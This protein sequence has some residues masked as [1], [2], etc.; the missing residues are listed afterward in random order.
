MWTQWNTAQ[1]VA[2]LEQD[3]IAYTNPSNLANSARDLVSTAPLLGLHLGVRSLLI[4][5]SNMLL[6]SNFNFQLAPNAVVQGIQ[7]QLHCQRL[8]RIQDKT[9]QIHYQQLQGRNL[10]S[11]LAEDL[12]SYGSAVDLWDV[13][14]AVDWSS[15][16]FGVAI[17]LQPHR[18]IPSGNTAIIYSV[19]MRLYVE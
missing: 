3:Q 17:D 13:D 4:Q 5:D 14:A 10:A 15:P 2:Q 11:D 18:T 7:V 16:L 12:Q 9:I 6:F 1:T 19:D 8:S